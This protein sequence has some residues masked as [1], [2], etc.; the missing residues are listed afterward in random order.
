MVGVFTGQLMGV[1]IQD[2]PKD[3]PA[4]GPS[5]VLELAT[6]TRDKA[7]IMSVKCSVTDVM[8]Y[9]E[10]EGDVIDL[11]VDVAEWVLD[12]GKKGISCNLVSD[13]KK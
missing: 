6:R 10:K 13:S 7:A 11:T 2:A 1:R 8:A 4:A 9:K 12:N 3:R 5:G